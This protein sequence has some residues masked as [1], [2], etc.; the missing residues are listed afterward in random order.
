VPVLQWLT[1]I[2]ILPAIA[3]GSHDQLALKFGKRR[4]R[5]SIRRPYDLAASIQACNRVSHGGLGAMA[6]LARQCRGIA[7]FGVV[8]WKRDSL[9]RFFVVRELE[10]R[11]NLF[12]AHGRGC[13]MLGNLEREWSSIA[14]RRIGESLTP[15]RCADA[16][17]GAAIARLRRWLDAWL[18]AADVIYGRW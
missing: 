15:P 9:V 1:L 4:A 2:L 5:V 6:R 16:I 18:F 3:C 17:F 12:S 8:V 10:R 7:K 13:Q 14:W 11:P